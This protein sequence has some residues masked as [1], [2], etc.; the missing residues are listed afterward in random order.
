MNTHSRVAQQ[1]D[2][3]IFPDGVPQPRNDKYRFPGS[4]L[5]AEKITVKDKKPHLLAFRG[6]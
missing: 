3:G 5:W 2:K 4:S 1:A 6:F